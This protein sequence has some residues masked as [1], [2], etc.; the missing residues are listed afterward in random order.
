VSSSLE[1]L[2]A[3]AAQRQPAADWPTGGAP[4]RLPA[5]QRL[6]LVLVVVVLTLVPALICA[7]GTR[8]RVRIGLA[9]VSRASQ[10]PGTLLSYVSGVVAQDLQAHVVVLANQLAPGVDRS[11]YRTLRVDPA[12][13]GGTSGATISG[14]S[15]SPGWALKVLR[16]EAAK[17]ATTAPRNRAIWRRAHEVVL[18]ALERR[19]AKHDLPP[20]ARRRI[21]AEQAFVRVVAGREPPAGPLQVGN[22]VITLHGLRDRIVAAMPGNPP[23][24]N[25]IW[26]ATAGFALGM[27][28]C[29]A[30]VSRFRSR[31]ARTATMH[32][33]VETPGHTQAH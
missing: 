13:V 16:F 33:R 8:S 18:P 26:A 14:T 2:A 23:P 6:M 21:L 5:Y 17:I 28:L 7:S 9:P 30:W 10:S 22:A 25:P 12:I 27:A 19:L 20:A 32:S 29:F 24:A 4:R 3:P 11:F 1:D 15:T 31:E